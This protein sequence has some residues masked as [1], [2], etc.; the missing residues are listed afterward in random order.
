[1]SGNNLYKPLEL[2]LALR[3]SLYPSYC[4][5]Y[6]KNFIIKNYFENKECKIYLYNKLFVIIYTININFNK[7]SYKINLFVH[8][9]ELF[10]NYPP[11]IYLIKKPKFAINKVYI[12][13]GQIDPNNF[14]I[15][16]DKFKRFDPFKNSIEDIINSIID[17]FNINF[18]LYK[19]YKKNESLEYGKNNVNTEK[20][21]LIIINK[22]KNVNNNKSNNINGNYSLKDELNKKIDD[23]IKENSELKKMIDLKEKENI[24]LKKENNEYK[25]KLI[26]YTNQINNLN[27]KIKDLSIINSELEKNKNYQNQSNLSNNSILNFIHDIE[28]YKNKLGFNLNEDDNLMIVTIITDDQKIKGHHF[29]CKNT[30][31]FTVLE[32]MFYNEYPQYRENSNSHYF[33]VNGQTVNKFKTLD[34]NKIKNSDIIS[35]FTIE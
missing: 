25:S 32:N 10:P 18:P 21:N 16:I 22:E 23:L 29:I 11:E 27:N 5:E 31:Q 2:D 20:A 6:I 30:L 3:K 19:D 15:N 24:N 33:V 7:K 12:L 17:E 26:Q 13:N 9:P 34:E 28:I 8:L 1:M 4:Q 35:L 14:K